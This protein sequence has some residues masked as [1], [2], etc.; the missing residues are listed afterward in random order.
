MQK[1]LDSSQTITTRTETLSSSSEKIFETH[2]S[3]SHNP[4]GSLLSNSSYHKNS[5]ALHNSAPHIYEVKNPEYFGS[6]SSLS[7]SNRADYPL[8]IEEKKVHKMTKK[9]AASHFIEILDSLRKN[10]TLELGEI[11]LLIR[12]LTMLDSDLKGFLKKKVKSDDESILGKRAR[13]LSQACLNDQRGELQLDDE[14]YPEE[15]PFLQG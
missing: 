11:N 14:R 2:Q 8:D 13:R 5:E 4:L 10:E 1:K 3:R 15:S 9:E 12:S 7:F 6:L